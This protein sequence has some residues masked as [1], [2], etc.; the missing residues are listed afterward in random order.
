MRD[1]EGNPSYI[2]GTLT[3][4]TLQKQA[5]E[6]LIIA[7]QL[8]EL[9]NKS[10]SE[11]IANISHEIR[12]PM[13]TILG[14]CDLLQDT[15]N[16]PQAQS[17]IEVIAVS[18]QTLLSLINDILDLSK[19]EAGKL[20]IIYEPINF[21]AIVTEVS[22]F[23]VQQAQQKNLDL[24]I[25][26]EPSVP[27]IIKFDDVRLRQILFNVVGNA[28]KFT[29]KGWV[30]I[31]AQAEPREEEVDYVQLIFN[32]TDT[33]TG[34]PLEQQEQIFEAFT[35]R[36]GQNNRKYGGA[37]LGLTITRRLTSMLGGEVYLESEINQG[38]TFTFRFSRVE[39]VQSSSSPPTEVVEEVDL[40]QYCPAKILIAED[41]PSHQDL[42]KQYFTNS[43]HQLF[44]T[45][46]GESA[47]SLA[48]SEDMD[49]VLMD[50][51]MPKMGGLEALVKFKQNQ[52][53]WDIPMIILTAWLRIEER[54][55]LE[56]ICQG[57]I[58][59]PFTK[60]QL[61]SA[62]KGILR[63]LDPHSEPTLL[64]PPLP[65]VYPRQS[66]ALIRELEALEATIW[67][68]IC[69]TMIIA[70]IRQFAR[71]LETLLQEYQAAEL[72]IYT[73][74]LLAYLNS[75][76]IEKFTAILKEFPQI[77]RSLEH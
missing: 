26:I 59:K 13:T 27:A 28:L 72:C 12:T 8:A 34:I 3:D 2:A 32:I 11:F 56:N 19:I 1:S 74:K 70:Y 64:L 63:P 77:K 68:E 30:K 55:Y 54:E 45:T 53:L 6:Q 69:R 41:N 14:F 38:S 20:A 9:A 15:V 33:G 39:V 57:I 4:I 10:K 40:N 16:D 18:G 49:L 52:K 65:K 29:E 7:K 67:P 17:Y 5:Q 62:L 21:A 42:L 58:L 51:K 35:Q 76:D 37:G 75:Y 43:H 24:L 25:H 47:F 71:Q 31:T 61:T 48:N 46:D 66:A 44:F 22:S 36:E 50:L 23:F 73:D 60:S